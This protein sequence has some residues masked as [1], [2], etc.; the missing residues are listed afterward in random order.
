MNW[1]KKR[2]LKMISKLKM[3]WQIIT[4]KEYVVA[5]ENGTHINCSGDFAAN[6]MFSISRIIFL[7]TRKIEKQMDSAVDEVNQILNSNNNV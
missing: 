1:Q 4:S 6:T 7:E 2:R 3:C 5:T